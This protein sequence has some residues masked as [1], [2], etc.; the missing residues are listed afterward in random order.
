MDEDWMFCVH[1]SGNEPGCVGCW[2]GAAQRAFKENQVLREA[3][4]GRGF[5]IL[6]GEFVRWDGSFSPLMIVP[7]DPKQLAQQLLLALDK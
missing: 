7:T 6:S 2:Y 5:T 3:I 1:S 4:E